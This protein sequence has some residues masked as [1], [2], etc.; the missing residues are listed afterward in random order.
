MKKSERMEEFVRGLGGH[1]DK[2]GFDPCYLA[3]FK[4]FN[5]ACYYEAHDVL[6]HLWLKEGPSSPDYCF[7]KGLIQLAGGFVHLKLQSAHPDHPKHGRRLHPA[8]RLF[9]L[10]VGNLSPYQSV[11]HGL[12]IDLVKALARRMVSL[13]EAS[14]CSVNPLSMDQSPILPI[15]VARKGSD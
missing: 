14:E 15:P 13:L 2:T 12:E 8:R 11:H 9:L 10:A 6:E 5:A 7:Y 3:Y 4:C 1:E